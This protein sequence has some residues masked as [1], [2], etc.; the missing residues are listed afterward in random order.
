MI[1]IVLYENFHVHIMF[2]SLCGTCIG[3]LIILETHKTWLTPNGYIRWGVSVRTSHTRSSPYADPMS[4]RHL[5]SF[6]SHSDPTACGSASLGTGSTCSHH[7]NA[8][9]TL[10]RQAVGWLRT[11]PLRFWVAGRAVSSTTAGR[12][13][14]CV[15]WGARAA[16]NMYIYRALGNWLY[17]LTSLPI[18]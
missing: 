16:G 18:I 8:G 13:R 15:W 17:L 4:P 5:V 6:A 12:Q 1:F 2:L 9:L 11:C 7:P 10:P 3:P 14:L